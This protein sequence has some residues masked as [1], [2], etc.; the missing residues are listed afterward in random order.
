MLAATANPFKIHRPHLGRVIKKT[1]HVVENVAH[2]VT[3]NVV[4]KVVPAVVAKA[5]VPVVVAK[6]VVAVAA[7]G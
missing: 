6:A 3:K 2:T 1:K 4:D 7:S 5:V